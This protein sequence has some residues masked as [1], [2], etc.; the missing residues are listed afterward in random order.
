MSYLHKRKRP[1]ETHRIEEKQMREI[2]ATR[3]RWVATLELRPRQ[4]KSLPRGNVVLLTRSD[5]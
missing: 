4:G 2:I 3:Q 5:F 1:C